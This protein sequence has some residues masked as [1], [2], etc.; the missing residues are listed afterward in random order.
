MK[1]SFII[2]LGTALV[3]VGKKKKKGIEE[4]RE[5]LSTKNKEYQALKKEIDKLNREINA[6]N[7][8]STEEVYDVYTTKIQPV[9]FSS[10]VDVQ[11]I[12]K[13]DKNVTVIPE[14]NGIIKKI[15]VRS[16]QNVRVGQVLAKIDD[17]ILRRNLA[18]IEN[19]LGLAEELFQKQKKLREQNVGTE[20]QFLESKNRRDGLVASK[21]TLVTQLS[22]FTVRSP[23]SGKIDEIFPNT[24][25]MASPSSPF[26]RIVS[27]NSLYVNAEVSEAFY[28]SV[29]IGDSIEAYFGT[30]GQREGLVVSYIGNYINPGNRTFKIGAALPNGNYPPNTITIIK[31]RSEYVP[32]AIV[33][34][35]NVLQ[36]D[37]KGYYVYIV[38]GKKASKVYVKIGSFYDGQSVITEGIF[39]GDEIVSKGYRTLSDDATVKINK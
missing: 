13:T 17:A 5:E 35:S 16:G 32:N 7:P 25:E 26:A 24:G 36:S 39:I 19:S 28:K 1:K 34:P 9:N 4:Q 20:V 6:S 15:F 27:T 30:T 14:A 22:K 33:V 3:L 12:V 29:S 31:V 21:E 2:L 23:I 37:L 11:G 38:K 8:V 10:Y 18:E